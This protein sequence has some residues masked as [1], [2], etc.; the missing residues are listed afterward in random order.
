MGAMVRMHIW[1]EDG[2]GS[3]S[4]WQVEV[5]QLTAG[6]IGAGA[7]HGMAEADIAIIGGGITG[8]SAAL[9][10]ARAGARAVVLEGRRIAAG[11]SGR[12]GGFLLGGTS[13]TYGTVIDRYGR[14][15]ARRIWAFN[16]SNQAL[17]VGLVGELAERGWDC[18]YRQTGSLR[19]A[20]SERELANVMRGVALMHEDGWEAEPVARTDLPDVIR[21][22]YFGA[23]YYPRDAQIQPARFVTGIARLAVEAGAAIYEESPVTGIE[24]SDA[25]SVVTAGGG[26]V[27]AR[28]LLLATNAWSGDIG[29][30]LGAEWLGQVI[31]PTRGQVLA[32]APVQARLFACPCYADEGYQYWRQL[33]DGRLVVGGWRNRSFETEASADE[34]PGDEVQRHLDGFVRDTLGLPDLPIEHRWAGIMAFSP[35]ELPLVGPL[36]GIHNCYIAGGYT[37]HGNAYALQASRML[38]DLIAGR[39]H[40]D[41]DLFAPA[42]LA[43]ASVLSEQG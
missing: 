18:G 24:V 2:V 30:A 31:V 42:R 28:T 7:L 23:A 36:P 38:A 12:N 8:T 13:E 43:P 17:A 4:F 41:A 6:G 39:Q 19:I 34:T 9:W 21:A 10:L 26:R 32:T 40:P 5:E 35:D 3:T 25:G 1:R 22:A 15:P 33:D 14:E 27:H 37:G 29:R 20:A 11:A 16:V